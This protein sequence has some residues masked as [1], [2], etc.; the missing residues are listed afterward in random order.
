MVFDLR[1]L[2]TDGSIFECLIPGE[3][4][5]VKLEEVN[6]WAVKGLRVNIRTLAEGWGS[7]TYSREEVGQSSLLEDSDN[8]FDKINDINSWRNSWNMRKTEWVLSCINRF[9]NLT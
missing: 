5:I 7:L 3:N 1:L 2:G 6:K 8:T 9:S 4:P